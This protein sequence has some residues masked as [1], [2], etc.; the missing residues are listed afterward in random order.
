MVIFNHVFLIVLVAMNDVGTL[1]LEITFNPDE[2]ISN[3]F[4]WQ[5][6]SAG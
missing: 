5:F 3:L 4:M 6:F 1:Y 2:I